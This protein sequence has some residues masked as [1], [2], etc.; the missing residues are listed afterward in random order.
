MKIIAGDFGLKGSAYISRD[1]KL[2]IE[3]NVRGVYPGDS[4]DSISA[5]KTEQRRFKP[6]KFLVFAVLLILIGYF[7][8]TLIGALIGLTLSVIAAFSTEEDNVLDVSFKD[9]K[10]A[11]FVCTPRQMNS[12]YAL[13]GSKQ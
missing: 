1:K 7:F 13:K 6:L 12:L 3:S 8:L 11:S 2:V 10:K 5:R 4:I 9:N